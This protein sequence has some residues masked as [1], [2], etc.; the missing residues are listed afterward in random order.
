MNAKRKI[1]YLS[2]GLISLTLICVY[3]YGL[4]INKDVVMPDEIRPYYDSFLKEAKQRGQDF[5]DRP[6]TIKIA[7]NLKETDE[8]HQFAYCSY[9]PTPTIY[10]SSSFWSKA[11]N[12]GKEIIL[13]HELTHC[14]WFKNH[15][16]GSIHLMNP[17]ITES[18]INLYGSYKKD[19]LNENFDKT[20]Y[21]L[22]FDDIKEFFE[23]SVLLIFFVSLFGL[24]FLLKLIYIVRINFVTKRKRTEHVL[25]RL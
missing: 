1:L 2:T 10:V 8:F 11:N 24:S 13:Y 25:D 19:M 14:L 17:E 4:F 6:I 23:G 12:L 20:K 5:S 7:D 22:S 18:L 9:L 16:R 15:Y 3:V 21:S